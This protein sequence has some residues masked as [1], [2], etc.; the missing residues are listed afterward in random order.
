MTGTG[1]QSYV[2]NEL[3]C[4]WLLP[5]QWQDAKEAHCF[6]SWQGSVQ[7]S[8][9]RVCLHKEGSQWLSLVLPLSK[10][11]HFWEDPGVSNR[12][13]PGVRHRPMKCSGTVWY[14]ELLQAARWPWCQG[15]FGSPGEVEGKPGTTRK[16]A[17]RSQANNHRNTLVP[18]RH[19]DRLCEAAR[20]WKACL[21]GEDGSW[22]LRELANK[23]RLWMGTWKKKPN[24]IYVCWEPKWTGYYIIII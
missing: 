17:A 11:F 2:W 7:Q 14:T 22:C 16:Q 19:G 3:S 4:L 10:I 6:H 24:K 5:W 1:Q 12:S 21:K 13:A 20:C 18:A 23:T 15:L 9:D 8:P